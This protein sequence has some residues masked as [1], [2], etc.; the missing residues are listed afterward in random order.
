MIVDWNKYL[1]LS[2]IESDIELMKDNMH[3]NI[4][5]H[6]STISF[7]VELKFHLCVLN[8]ANVFHCY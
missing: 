3:A 8:C 1:N 5:G 4:P 7:T 2:F 6:S